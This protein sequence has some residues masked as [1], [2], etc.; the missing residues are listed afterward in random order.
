MRKER[1]LVDNLLQVLT[2]RPAEP[3]LNDL[4]AETE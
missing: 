3:Y 4:W 1:S 2:F